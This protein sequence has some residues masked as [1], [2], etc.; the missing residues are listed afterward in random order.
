MNKIKTLV[1]GGIVATALA[2]GSIAG[3]AV[4]FDGE[5]GTG[6]VGRGDVID[7][8][9]LGKAS[10]V[11]TPI[12]SFSTDGTWIQ[13]CKRPV[14]S[15]GGGPRVQIG[16]E[17]EDRSRGGATVSYQTETE[18]KKSKGSGNITGYRLQGIDDDTI[19]SGTAPATVCTG[20][21]QVDR[22]GEYPDVTAVPG[23]DGELIFD[24]GNKQ[25]AWTYDEEAGAW[26]P[27]V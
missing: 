17:Y 19:A 23:A 14:Y 2:A 8:P 13:S 16:W 11:D 9:E 4:T 27:V 3:A 20:Q 12:I 24:D 25:G 7:H 26:V 18:T 22:G 1:G 6:S 5:A 10:L 21:W 15:T